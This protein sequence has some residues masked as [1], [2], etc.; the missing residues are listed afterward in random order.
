VR[1]QAAFLRE[2]GDSGVTE[3]AYLAVLSKRLFGD[4]QDEC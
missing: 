4:H 3:L 2:G 1:L